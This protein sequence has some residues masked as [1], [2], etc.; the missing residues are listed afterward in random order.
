MTMKTTVVPGPVRDAAPPV[1]PGARTLQGA[2]A[3]HRGRP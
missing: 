1:A 3:P 2:A